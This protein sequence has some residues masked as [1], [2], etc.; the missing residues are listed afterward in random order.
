MKTLKL[1]KTIGTGSKH[2]VCCRFG[3][4]L[5]KLDGEHI[6]SHGGALS[7]CYQHLQPLMNITSVKVPNVSV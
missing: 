5:N 7:S 3:T 4:V 1:Q 6:A 2:A